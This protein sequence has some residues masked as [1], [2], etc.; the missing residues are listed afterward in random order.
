MET[1]ILGDSNVVRYLPK[2]KETSSDPSIQSVSLIKTTNEVLLRDALSNPRSVSPLIIVAALTNL[3][4][5]K[6]FEDY[7][8]LIE[9]CKSVFNDVQLWIQEGRNNLDGFAS[10]VCN[11]FIHNLFWAWE[12]LSVPFDCQRRSLARI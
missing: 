12:Y 8:L 7:D 3:V 11:H 6:Y 10:Q 5:S 1:L 9:H 2:L 4:T